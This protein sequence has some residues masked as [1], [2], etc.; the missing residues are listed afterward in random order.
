MAV[1]RLAPDT[2]IPAWALTSTL[3]SVT[4]TAEELSIVCSEED[5]VVQSSSDIKV[6]RGWMALKL[7]GP[8]PFSMTGVL[9]SFLQPLATAGIPIFALSTFDTD[10]VLIKHQT[11]DDA[12]TALRNSGHELLGK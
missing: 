6:E 8:F 9:A 1:C 7:E 5:V 10:F 2:P 4:R 3:I 12:I 11:L